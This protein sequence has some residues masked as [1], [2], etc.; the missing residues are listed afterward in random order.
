MPSPKTT[1]KD[2]ITG[3]IQVTVPTA[4]HER[5]YV[6]VKRLKLRDKY[7]CYPVF[8]IAAAMFFIDYLE[9]QEKK[10]NRER[11]ERAG[12]DLQPIIWSRGK[13]TG[14]LIDRFV[15]YGSADSAW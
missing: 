7:W 5:F 11:N 4:Q 12:H 13:K 9:A 3:A 2:R 15:G 14:A 8:F 10:E 6:A 1:F